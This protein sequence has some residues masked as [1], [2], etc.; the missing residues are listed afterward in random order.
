MAIFLIAF[1]LI[2]VITIAAIIINTESSGKALGYLLLVVVFPIIGIIVYFTFGVN[3]R[4]RKIYQKKLLADK[5]AFPELDDEL[6]KSIKETLSKHKDDLKHFYKLATHNAKEYVLTPSNKATLLINGE[7]KFPRVLQTL[8]NAKEHIHIEYYI[9][10]NDAIGTEIGTILKEKAKSGI[11]VRMIYD[12]FGSQ[13]IR[14]SFV[15]ELREAGVEVAPFYKIRWL[16][17]ANRIN[18]RNHR[19]IIVVDGNVGY[20]GG[21]NV[22]DKYINKSTS[23]LYWRDTHL[24]L[25]GPS[26]LS[27]QYTF[28]TDWNFCSKQSIMFENKYFPVKEIVNQ[29]AGDQLTQIVSSGPDS[30]YNGIMYTIM[31]AIILAKNEILITTPYFIPNTSLLDTLKIATKSGVKVIL[32]VPGISDSYIVNAVSN[33]YYVELLRIGVEIYKYEKGFVHAKT[34]VIDEFVSFIGTANLDERSLELN[35]EVNSIVYDETLAKQLKGA[36]IEDLKYSKKIDLSAW[37]KRPKS[38]RFTERIARLFAPLM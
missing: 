27:L 3:Y 31:Q 2:I 17:L 22:S 14:R 20:V 26:V 16:F 19:K 21:I 5:K 33:S 11:K 30:E 34:I 35:F 13:S 25:Q 15:Q 8:R 23:H 12:D 18:Y 38:V 6:E 36:F 24:E 4:K 10:E 7:Q 29:K 28:L 37:L 1:Y 32:L 9:Y